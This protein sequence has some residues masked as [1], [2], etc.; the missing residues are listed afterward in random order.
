MHEVAGVTKDEINKRF[1]HGDLCFVTGDDQRYFGI[2][3]GHA[4]KCYIRG[5]GYLLNIDTHDVYLY[6]AVTIP[7]MR[8]Q[9]VIDSIRNVMCMHYINQG[10]RKAYVLIDDRND[11]MKT[12]FTESG[13]VRKEYIRYVKFSRIG[14]RVDYDYER[15]R[16]GIQ[17]LT[18]EPTDCEII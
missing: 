9:H 10:A 17:L 5:A 14:L 4:G 12:Y 7:G 18:A 13:Y 2:A 3:W 11:K 6:G 16:F 8:R 1:E 15:K